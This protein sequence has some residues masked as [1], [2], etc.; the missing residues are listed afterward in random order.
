[1]TLGIHIQYFI[2]DKVYYADNV[3]HKIYPAHIYQVSLC[4]ESNKIVVKY[5]FYYK[6]T[7]HIGYVNNNRRI[8]RYKCITNND[9]RKHF[10]KNKDRAKQLSRK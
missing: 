3:N 9:C 5:H 10:S 2:G 8:T 6:T 7:H 1:M 4:K